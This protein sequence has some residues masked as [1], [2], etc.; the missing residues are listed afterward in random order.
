MKL[1]DDFLCSLKKINL[2]QISQLRKKIDSHKNIEEITLDDINN[3]LLKKEYT[4]LEFNSS[5]E[6][7]YKISDE[8][9]KEGI[10]SINF[11]EDSYPEK[12][13]NI[14]NPPKIIY[15]KGNKNLL[16]SIHSLGVVGSRKPTPYGIWATKAISKELA[17]YGFCIISGLA[18]G[19]DSI[20]HEAALNSDGETIS[21]FGTPINKVYPNKN[22]NLANRIIN[23]G[24]LIISERNMLE[25]TYP[26]HFA[27]RNRI[28]SGISDGVLV[29]EAGNKSGTLITANYALE[30]GKTVFSVPGNIN[31]AN[32]M[33]TNALIKDGACLVMSASDILTEFG[34][35]AEE[36]EKFKSIDGLSDIENEVLKYV[37]TQGSCHAEYIAIKTNMKIQDIVAILNILNIKGYISYDGFMANAKTI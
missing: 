15:Y 22:K 34:I 6:E 18:Y 32:S 20:S 31:S 8:N 9:G 33:G 29:I 21:V 19:I 17:D 5:K 11:F 7:F 30:Q 13:K 12:L 24:G 3:L 26:A 4:S 28:I 25:N 35:D 10:G 16:N 2:D 37:K 27:L 23:E 14:Y 1:I 36:V